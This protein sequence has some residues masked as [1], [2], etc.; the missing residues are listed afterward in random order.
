MK[1]CVV[2]CVDAV[3]KAVGRK[4]YYATLSGHESFGH[5]IVTEAKRRGAE[6]A[7]ELI[8]IGDGA[9]WIW[10]LCAREFPKAIQVLDWYHA[11]EHLSRRR[12]RVLR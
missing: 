2:Y 7:R 3:G 11:L 8:F 5:K 9:K 1:T 6:L 12:P 4:T 10:N